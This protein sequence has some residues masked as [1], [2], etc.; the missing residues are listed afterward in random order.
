MANNN[1]NNLALRSILDKDKLNGTNFVDWQRNLSIVLC[2]DEKEYV[3]EKPIPPAPPANAPK[4]VKD[5]YEK[6][7][8]DDNQVSCVMLATM[9]TELQKP[10]EDMK[11]H[12]MIV[13][14]RQLYQGQSRHER[15]L[16][17][18][19]LF[20]CKLSSGNPVGPQVLKMIGYI[21][22]LEKLGFS[23]Q[24]ELATDL[25][26]Q[27]LPELYKGFVMNYM[28][29]D[30]DKP[31]PELLKILQTAEEN[32]TKGKGASVL[33]V[34]G[35]KGKPKKGIKI[36]ARTVGK[37]KSKS[38]SSATQKPVGGVAKGKCH[39]CGKAGHWR[40]N[41]KTY[42]ATKKKEGT[43]ISSEV[44][45]IEVNM[46]ISSSWVL[47][48]GCG[49]HICTT[50]Q[51]LKQSRRLARGE[52]ELR[53]GNG[54]PV[55]ALAIGT[56][57]LVLPS[58]LMLELNDC[59]YVPAISRNIISVSC[60]DKSGFIISIKD[61][62]LSVYR[63]NVFYAN[64]NMTNGLYVLDLDMPLDAKSDKCFFVGYPKET[65]GYSFYHPIDKK[66]FVARNGVFLEKEFLSIATSGRKI[67]LEEIRDDEE[68]TAPV[69][70]HELEEQTVVPQNAQDTQ[71]P[72]RSN[73]LRT[74]P[75]RYGFLLTFEGDVML[76][77][78]DEPETYLEAISCPE[79]EE[80]RQAMQSEM[81][82]MYT[83]QSW[84]IRFHEI[85]I[86]FGF[87]RNSDESCVYKKVSGSA[88]VFL[89]LYVDD[90]LLI[91]NN[92]STLTTVKTWLSLSQS[93]YI[94]KVLAKFSMSESKRGS[95]PMVQGTSLSKT[96]GAST[97]EEVER[98]RTVPYASAIGSIMYAMVCTRPDVA[99]ALSVTSRYQSNP[100]ESHWTVVKNI[101]QYFRRTKDAFLVYGG[102]EELSIVG[103]TDA[104]FQT[105][106]DDF[107]S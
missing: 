51:G 99:F 67:E 85:V 35:G 45:V 33:M 57:S 68:T 104:S 25:I 38:T 101:L 75:E 36:K 32:L 29:H 20:S 18:K 27:S 81:D 62:S 30:L 72:R 28:M 87:E 2:M 31:L 69:L 76:I 49:S 89:A 5:A 94:D 95:L 82:S 34:Q 97:P 3:L 7:V 107:K 19:A 41:C 53:V 37:P 46:S 88:V 86:G 15:F 11:A 73:R 42:L 59:L 93:T 79:A 39:H 21:T 77:D 92:I 74:Q 103:Y 84:N 63:K 56:Y 16:V 60:L 102:K 43:T 106:R 100:G 9:I 83:N 48:T 64:A 40:R 80:W 65:R 13:A 78:Q 10:H 23:L 1:T 105:D 12:E 90:I 58:G 4:A 61:K 91:G 6:H 52:I 17:S 22:N 47:D 8:K 96:Q 66:V 55:A 50:M 71:E 70:E 14:L 26:L 54:A 24:K 44:Y 98:M